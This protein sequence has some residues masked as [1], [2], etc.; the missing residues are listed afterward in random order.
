MSGPTASNPL[1]V[2]GAVVATFIENALKR[3]IQNLCQAAAVPPWRRRET[4]SSI[5]PR[6]QPCERR[7]AKEKSTISSK[8]ILWEDVLLEVH[9]GGRLMSH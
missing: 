4:S 8:A 1:D 7:T 2:C 5:I 3:Q 6:L 9:L